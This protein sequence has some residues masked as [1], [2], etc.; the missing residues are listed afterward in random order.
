MQ[1]RS[2]LLDACCLALFAGSGIATAATLSKADQQFMTMAAKTDM[3]EAHEGQVAEEHANRADVKDF[4]KTLV[5]DHTNSYE[6]LSQL[7]QKEG[8][9][10]PKGINVAKDPSLKQLVRLKGDRFDN[11]FAR[12]E[13]A[14]HRRA[15][16]VFRREAEHGGNA[17]VKA[18]AGEMIPVLEKHL[19]LAEQCAKDAKR[20]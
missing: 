10:I 6:H 12:D 7:A 2:V 1:I 20:S 15:I 11:V 17:D 8:V 14:A 4:A 19:R 9:S 3:T 5:Q 16:V 18:Y 13:I